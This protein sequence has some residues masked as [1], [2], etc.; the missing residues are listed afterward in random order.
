M[1]TVSEIVSARTKKQKKPDEEELRSLPDRKALI[2]GRLSDFSQVRDSRES[3]REIALQFERAKQDGYKTGLDKATIEAWLRRI[4]TKEDPPGVMQDGEVI[5][6]CL[7][8]GVSASLPE[9]KRPDVQL[10]MQ[11]LREN[12]LGAI[13]VTEGA[14]RLSRDP[15]LLVSD[16]LLKLMKETNCKLRTPTEILSPR[17]D[18]DWTII[19]DDL[20]RGSEEN[21]TFNKRLCRRR[22]LKAARGEFVGEPIPPGYTVPITAIRSNGSRIYGKYERYAPHAEIDERVLQELVRQGF[23]EMKAHRALGGMTYPLFPADLQYMENLSSLRRAR[24]VEGV[25]YLISPSMI[26]SLAMNPKLVGWAIW[27]NT[28]PK[29][30]NHDG[31]VPEYLWLEAYQGVTSTIKRRGRSIRHEPL[32]WDGLLRCCNHEISLRVSGHTSKPA[33]RCQTEYSQGLGPSCFEIAAQYFDEPFTKV[34]LE[35]LDFTPLAEEVL[36]QM[37]AAADSSNLEDEERHGS[38]E[39]QDQEPGGSA[40]LEGRK[41]RS[42]SLEED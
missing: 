10:D 26:I 25:G 27:G 1:L 35:Q 22:E 9:D 6:N 17:I 31:A 34:V 28:E 14:N 16:T 18:R 24:K 30:G 3:V 32:E 29:P 11:L 33:Y 42:A 36:T 38:A 7:G 4:Q 20:L 8:M 23:S 19:H 2:K 39:E 21:K 37:E 41:I 15:D 5:V 12:Q 40:G 13:Y